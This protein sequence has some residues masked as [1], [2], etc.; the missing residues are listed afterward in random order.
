M[1]F[2]LQA[3][4]SHDKNSRTLSGNRLGQTERFVD[5]SQVSH[6]V[7]EGGGDGTNLI[8]LAGANRSLRGR[9]FDLPS[10]CEIARRIIAVNRLSGR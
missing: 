4:L 2:K 10:V 1:K 9:A 5:L 8:T 7:D 6:L 3:G